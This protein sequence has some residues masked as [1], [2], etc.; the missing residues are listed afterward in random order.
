MKAIMVMFD[1]LNKK[2]IDADWVKTPNF[3]RLKEKTVE[4]ENFY[5][6][7]LPC[8]PAR[9]ELHTGRVNFL[10]RSWGPIEPFDDSMPE[11][12]KNKGIY[13]HL[14]SDHG[15]YWE[16]GGATYHNRYNSWECIRGQEGDHWK[17]SVKDP[18]IP[19]TL[20]GHKMAD[21][22]RQD[23]V[24]RGHQTCTED[25]PQAKT[26]ELGLDFMDTNMNE[27][28]WFLQIET[29]DPHEPF[30]TQQEYK[31][32]YPHD[33][34]GKHFDWP[35]YAKVKQDEKTV[36]HVQ[37][38]YAALM[39]MCDAYLGKVLDK[40]DEN[41][42]WEDTMLIVNTDHGYLLGEHQWWGKN[43]QPFYNEIVNLPFYIWDPTLKISGE[44]RTGLAQT[45]DIPATILDFFGQE[46]PK[47]MEG[48][49]IKSIISDDAK[50]RDTAIFGMFGGHTNITDG[51]YV[52]MRGPKSIE[53]GP[54]YDYTLMPTHMNSLFKPEEFKG[55][56]LS[57]PFSFTKEAPLMKIPARG[58]INPYW[59]GTLLF[60]LENDPDQEKPF[61]DYEIEERLSN[62]LIDVMKVNDA[63]VEQY[64]RIGLSKT[65]KVDVK[66]LEN[67][68]LN[69]EQGESLELGN[70]ITMDKDTTR[71]LLFVLSYVPKEK[72]PQL[73]GGV[74]GMLAQSGSTELTMK[75]VEGLIV[76]VIPAPMNQMLL[77]L[78]KMML[79]I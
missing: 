61:R 53:N 50:V 11:I 62:Q 39:S 79:D 55:M 54:Q 27:D 74:K 77:G 51:R 37:Y 58:F 57:E 69:K 34:D 41:N 8:M 2:Y 3:D 18:E 9:R 46:I 25:M 14:V 78:M 13:T 1:S 45:I 6:G 67:I 40:M 19:Q 15:H 52:Y 71:G 21:L 36:S 65:E 7:S 75:H 42:M 29:F 28:N 32:L 5:A 17:G 35:D 48:K 20:S 66:Y 56:T 22:W 49:S 72:H 33:Y 12:L 73:L 26:F 68:E 4:F 63:P 59:Y 64:D 23:W 43:V 31:N 24:N 47:D 30:F 60:D 10:H 70:G 16:D 76:N 44:K 38:E